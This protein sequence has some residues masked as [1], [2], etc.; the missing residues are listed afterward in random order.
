ME[1]IVGATKTKTEAKN[2]NKLPVYL[3][4]YSVRNIAAA[5][6]AA[7]P[8]DD[9]YFYLWHQNQFHCGRSAVPVCHSF[10]D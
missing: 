10:F 5:A 1:H 9:Y 3:R 2:I 6:A 7:A 4:Y 8:D